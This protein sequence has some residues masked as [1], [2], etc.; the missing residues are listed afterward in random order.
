V[1]LKAAAPSDK[2][3]KGGKEER[4]EMKKEGKTRL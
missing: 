2:V 3:I 1:R 4:R